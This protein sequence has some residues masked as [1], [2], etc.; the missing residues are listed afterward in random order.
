MA[1]HGVFIMTTASTITLIASSV[2]AAVSVNVNGAFG[3]GV[4]VLGYRN[5]SGVFEPYGGDA[6]FTVPGQVGI[7]L[8][9]GVELMADLSGI[10]TAP[11]LVIELHRRRR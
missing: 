4:L 11:N 5:A 8:G 2:D 10:A 7:E 6:M 3:G 1:T 9:E